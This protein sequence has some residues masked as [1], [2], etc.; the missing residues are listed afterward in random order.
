MHKRAA[1]ALGPKCTRGE[2][3]LAGGPAQA[4]AP[5]PHG[6]YPETAMFYQKK[7]SNQAAKETQVLTTPILFTTSPFP[8][9]TS[10]FPSTTSPFPSTTS[11]FISTTSPFSS[12][13]VSLDH[14]AVSLDHF[15]VPSSLPLPFPPH[16]HF[17]SLVTY[18]SVP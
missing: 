8:F 2:A 16:L 14:F 1:L 11:P 13:P 7:L 10:P 6:Y 3:A 9:T 4:S 5:I 18:T 17:R 12:F 15:L